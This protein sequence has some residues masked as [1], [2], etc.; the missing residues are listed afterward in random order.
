MPFAR[1][2]TMPGDLLPP[3]TTTTRVPT[4]RPAPADRDRLARAIE[5]Y[6]AVQRRNA[7]RP[8]SRVNLGALYPDQGR[9]VE[10]EPRARPCGLSQL[11][12]SG[13]RRFP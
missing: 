3:R 4:A 5:E 10:A 13:S 12:A 2:A 9:R 6:V 8:E 11:S 7:D 1:N